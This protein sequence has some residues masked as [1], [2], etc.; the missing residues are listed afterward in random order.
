MA[1]KLAELRAKKEDELI[2]DH[3][4]DAPPY[5]E[6]PVQI[7]EELARRDANKQG[8]RMV[9][10]TWVITVLTVVITLLTAVNVYVVLVMP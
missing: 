6:T 8:K 7:R 1:Y 5:P 9:N 10:L 2:R 4:R 3:D